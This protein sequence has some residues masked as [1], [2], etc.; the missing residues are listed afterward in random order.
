MD[1]IDGSSKRGHEYSTTEIVG[2]SGSAYGT[3]R[4]LGRITARRP[5]TTRRLRLE[6]V[7]DDVPDGISISALSTRLFTQ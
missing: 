4:R 1:Y 7:S 3:H 6:A 2:T 5:G